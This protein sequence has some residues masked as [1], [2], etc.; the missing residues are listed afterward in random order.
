[1][2]DF[3]TRNSLYFSDHLFQKALY[4]Q[5]GLTFKYFTSYAMNGYDP[6]LS[7]FYVQNSTELGGYPVV[8]FFLIQKL[9]KRGFSL[10]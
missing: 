8:D 10:N 7:E 4:L 9:D 2:P 3:V 6:V 1:M 5:T